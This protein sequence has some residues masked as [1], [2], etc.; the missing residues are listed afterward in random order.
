M[1]CIAAV[2]QKGKVWM[3]SDS[4]ATT[5]DGTLF[6]FSNPKLFKFGRL[7]I[8]V[9]GHDRIWNVLLYRT[10]W[11]DPPKSG[12]DRWSNIE[13]LQA[14]KTA[15][16]KELGIDNTDK[17]LEESEVL[18]GVAGRLYQIE[19]TLSVARPRENYSA[20]GSGSALALGALYA[21][22]KSRLGPRERLRRALEAAACYRS[23]VAPPWHWEEV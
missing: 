10:D 20:V 7:I 17:Y 14:I 9:A 2:A 6:T 19:G 3:C 11:P 1:T 4:A 5:E 13:L 12:F 16:T 23:D 8:G 22:Q 18:I 21:T 15:L